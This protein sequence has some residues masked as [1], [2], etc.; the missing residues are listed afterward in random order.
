MNLWE[1]LLVLGGA[2]VAAVGF[3]FG[4]REVE[5]WWTRRKL[6]QQMARLTV[7]FENLQRMLV[8]TIAPAIQ[9]LTK[10]FAE[11][12]AAVSREQS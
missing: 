12:G 3:G 8:E 7:E 1:M 10:A 6:R 4:A 2:S 5:Q 9:K 11:F